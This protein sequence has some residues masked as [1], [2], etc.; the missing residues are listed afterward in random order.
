MKNEIFTVANF[1]SFLRILLTPIF[2]Y[3]L[4]NNQPYFEIYALFVFIIASITDAYDGYFAR[5]YKTVSKFGIFLDPLA[6][7][8][9]MLA[10]FL[11]F[12]FLGIIPLW[13]V[14]VI[15]LRDLMITVLRIYFNSKNK[16]ME[17]RVTAKIKTGLQIGV[18]IFILV[19][20]VTQRLPILDIIKTPVEHFLVSG[21][22]GIYILMLLITLF[23]AWTGIEYLIVNKKTIFNK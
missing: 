13:M 15:F 4:F 21:Y 18:A 16:S 10:T 23:T 9:L 7:K 1:F 6:D 22:H 5:K 8:V 11:S 3:F 17:T 20:I 12:V 2:L 19:Y 14:I